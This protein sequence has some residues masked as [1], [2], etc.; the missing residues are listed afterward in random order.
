MENKKKGIIF[1][2]ACVVL[3]VIMYFVLNKTVCDSTSNK[4]EVVS[5]P[6]LTY[7]T[8]G[9]WYSPIVKVTVKNKTSDTIKVQ[10]SCTVYASDGNATTGLTS[11]ITTLVPGETATI[12][13]TTS[14][15]YS[16]FNYSSICA[17]FGKVEYKFY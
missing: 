2:V 1:A 17:S 10:L 4:L 6:Y 16:P 15:T 11:F 8:D 14:Y 13:A 3:A 9:V 5:E 12:T 7:R